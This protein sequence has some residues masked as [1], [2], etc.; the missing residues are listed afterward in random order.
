MQFYSEA[1]TVSF[2]DPPE[3][4]GRSVLAGE[5][6]GKGLGGS[7]HKD[8]PKVLL[9]GWVKKRN[10]WSAWSGCVG[11]FTQGSSKGIDLGV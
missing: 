7:P 4:L 8:V 3:L 9:G 10:A 5:S 11:Q 6:A 1:G 2:T